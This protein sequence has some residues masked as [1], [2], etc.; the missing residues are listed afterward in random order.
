MSF[1]QTEPKNAVAEPLGESD[2]STT[3][4]TTPAVQRRGRRLVAIVAAVAAS[5]A[6]GVAV[7][8]VR[9][10]GGSSPA[11]SADSRQSADPLA[12]PMLAGIAMD[13]Q[14]FAAAVDEY[15]AGHEAAAT[16][17]LGDPML[18]SIAMDPQSFAAAVDEYLA[19][20]G[21]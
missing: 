10:E 3:A 16:V 17:I 1:T 15:L 2:R 11:P 7:V 5:L 14:S 9:G 12:D 20:S 18:A 19:S 21:R 6:I 8:G 13:P 4:N